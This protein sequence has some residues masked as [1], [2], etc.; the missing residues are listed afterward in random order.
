MPT[1]RIRTFR[2][3]SVARVLLFMVAALVAPPA[4]AALGHKA[5]CEVRQVFVQ[6]IS[7]RKRSGVDTETVAADYRAALEEALRKKKLVLAEG[8]S[9]LGP[10]DVALTVDI[11]AWIDRTQAKRA[12]LSLAASMNVDRGGEQIWSGD[13]SPGG[14]SKLLH[15]KNSDPGNLA[16][17]TA[18]QL[19]DACRSDWTAT[20]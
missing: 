10:E 3:R 19:M 11:R 5:S 7:I 9:A 16:K 20:P 17:K 13:V 12:L 2:F 8:L 6:E 15:F 18:D 4:L 1:T 14:A